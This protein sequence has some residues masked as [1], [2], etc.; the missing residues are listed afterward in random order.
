M[1]AIPIQR[2]EP[3]YDVTIAESPESLWKFVEE[4]CCTLFWRLQL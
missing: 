3:E 2:Y 1:V 4:R